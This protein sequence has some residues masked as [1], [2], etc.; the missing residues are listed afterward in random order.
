MKILKTFESFL[1]PEERIEQKRRKRENNK[2]QAGSRP[3]IFDANYRKQLI[4]KSEFV[5]LSDDEKFTKDYYDDFIN[6]FDNMGIPDSIFDQIC[7]D[8]K[9]NDFLE[10]AK[11]H[12][13]DSEGI[14]SEGS[15][16]DDD[17]IY[18]FISDLLDLTVSL[19]Y[20]R[21]EII[22]SIGEELFNVSL[23]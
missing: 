22:A 19:D 23:Y 7:D 12:L 1:T 20:P 17:N 11:K 18:N 15:L 3:N 16:E 10:L 13:S 6:L 8:I 2:K 14:F 4:D 5:K 21:H 9:F